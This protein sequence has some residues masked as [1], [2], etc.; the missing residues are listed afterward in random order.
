MRFA[1]RF[2]S[3]TAI[4]VGMTTA[5]AFGL[6]TRLLHPGTGMVTVGLVLLLLGLGLTLTTGPM[7]GALMASAPGDLGSTASA[8]NNTARQIGSAL[9]IAVLGTLAGDPSGSGFVDGLHRAGLVAAVCWAIAAVAAR[10]VREP[11]S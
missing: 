9:G 10:W 6:L 8:T 2:G 11:I 4:A 5:A 7:V 1:G 3:G